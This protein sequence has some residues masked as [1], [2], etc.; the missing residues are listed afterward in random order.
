VRVVGATHRQWVIVACAKTVRFMT[1]EKP[2]RKI[3]SFVTST[4]LN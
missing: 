4:Q 1:L 2:D 3:K